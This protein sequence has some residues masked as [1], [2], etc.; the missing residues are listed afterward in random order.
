MR[1]FAL[2]LFC[3]ALALLLVTPAC[4]ATDGKKV[5]V[6]F[7]LLWTIDDMGWTTAAH[8]GIEY[9][10]KELGDQVEVSYTEKVLAADAE[11]VIRNYA[12]QGYDIIFGTT[13][14]HM[15]PMLMVARDFPKV[16]FEHCSGYKTAANMGNYFG[17]MYQGEYLSG[18]MAGLMGFTNVGTVATNPIPE[19][20]RGINAFTIGLMKGLREAGHSFDMD[21]LNTVVWLKAWRDPVNETT[22][23]ETLVSRG[24]DLIRQMADTPDSSLAACAKGVPALGY[25][26][27]AAKY[28]ADC[29]LLSAIWN[30]GPYYVDAVKRVAAGTWKPQAYWGGFDKEA[31]LLTDFHP[32]VPEPVRAKV[33]TEAKKLAQG[34]DTIFSG[35][36]YDNTG[37]LMVPEGKQASDK[38]LLTMRWLIRGVSGRIPD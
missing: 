20:V 26:A 28:G 31:I 9:L 38:D 24:H 4:M 23:A 14:E 37:K 25:G 6:A 18:Y 27:D 15:D 11:R 3:L 10:K 22:L 1:R 32:S 5:K 7:A 21:K 29:V 2:P 16:A 13:F 33:L 12:M 35:P 8:E 34:Q 36:L 30:W 17:R 19:P